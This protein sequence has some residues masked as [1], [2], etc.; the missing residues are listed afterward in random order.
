MFLMLHIEIPI[1]AREFKKCCSNYQ[2]FE[3]SLIGVRN[4]RNYTMFI[5]IIN[6]SSQVYCDAI[7]S[8]TYNVLLSFDI[9]GQDEVKFE[10]WWNNDGYTWLHLWYIFSTYNCLISYNLQINRT[11][12]FIYI[13][14]FF[15]VRSIHFNGLGKQDFKTY[16][17]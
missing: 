4:L 8:V 1:Y 16:V 6:L 11:F 5:S 12:F 17:A 9:W 14:F 10:Q 3:T 7:S 13:R 15:F 2:K